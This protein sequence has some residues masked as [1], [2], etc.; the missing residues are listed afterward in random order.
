MGIFWIL[1][2]NCLWNEGKNARNIKT[3]KDKDGK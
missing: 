1:A 2:K 3:N